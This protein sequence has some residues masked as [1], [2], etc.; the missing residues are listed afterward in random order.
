MNAW[1]QAIPWV[2]VL[3]AQNYTVFCKTWFLLV[4]FIQNTFRFPHWRS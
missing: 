3:S 2:L 4:Q 1:I